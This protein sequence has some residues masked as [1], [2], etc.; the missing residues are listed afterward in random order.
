[1]IDNGKIIRDALESRKVNSMEEFVLRHDNANLTL[2][3][4][5]RDFIRIEFLLN[6][7]EVLDLV[8]VI[9]NQQEVID[10]FSKNTIKNR[11]LFWIMWGLT[12][13]CVD[14]PI[15]YHE[16]IKKIMEHGNRLDGLLKDRMIQSNFLNSCIVG[17]PLKQYLY[18][19]NRALT[20]DIITVYRGFLVPKDDDVR[21]GRYVIGNDDEKDQQDVG[22]GFSFTLD[23]KVAIA[24][25]TRQSSSRMLL[26]GLSKILNIKENPK[27]FSTHY[28]YKTWNQFY[29]DYVQDHEKC[30]LNDDFKNLVNNTAGKKSLSEKHPEWKEWNKRVLNNIVKQVVELQGKGFSRFGQKEFQNEKYLGFDVRPCVAR[31]EIEKKNI[32]NCFNLCGQKE[33]ICYPED[34]KLIR[35]DFVSW[36]ESLEQ[37]DI[38]Q[39]DWDE[40]IYYANRHFQESSMIKDMKK[41]IK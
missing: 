30:E 12:M 24:F 25:A 23:R 5:E 6:Q 28:G 17:L 32:K 40:K 7:K 31:Y 26:E 37:N 36:E 9:E 2:S 27:L 14:Y 15:Q 34:A 16:Q 13:N 41:L 22:I 8:S 1:M 11:E 10:F 19:F 4:N 39:N 21:K 29:K 18:P 35:Y 33:I 38:M 20:K 3:S